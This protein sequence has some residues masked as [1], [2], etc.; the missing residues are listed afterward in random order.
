MLFFSPV[1]I[2]KAEV[3]RHFSNQMSF[4]MSTYAVYTMNTVNVVEWN[5]NSVT[6]RHI[7]LT[8]YYKYCRFYPYYPEADFGSD[9]ELRFK[10]SHITFKISQGLQFA[11]KNVSTS[12]V[13]ECHQSEREKKEKT[14][15]DVIVLTRVREA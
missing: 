11:M 2:W 12:N 14:R 7:R 3:Q 5:C 13:S 8:K 9:L 1:F 10:Q 6:N 4:I 15:Q